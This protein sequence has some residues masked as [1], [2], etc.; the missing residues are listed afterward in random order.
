V[1][2]EISIIPLYHHLIYITPFPIFSW[3]KRSYIG[4]LVALKCFVV[5]ICHTSNINAN[6]PNQNP[7]VDILHNHLVFLVLYFDLLAED[8]LVF[9]RHLSTPTTFYLTLG[10]TF[11]QSSIC[12][13]SESIGQNVSLTCQSTEL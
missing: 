7:S 13:I 12:S 8:E 11:L 3:L 2:I 5:C 6:V 1:Q 10:M 9:R 4:C